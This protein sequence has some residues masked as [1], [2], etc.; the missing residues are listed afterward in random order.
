MLKLTKSHR[1][2][3]YSQS[4]W[5]ENISI[6][7]TRRRA[8]AANTFE[9]DFSKLMNNVKYEKTIKYKKSS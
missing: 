3:S 2:I 7:N 6:E 4:K 5:L 9:K 8:K 1:V